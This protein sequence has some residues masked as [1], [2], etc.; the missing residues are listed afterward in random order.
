MAAREGVLKR[1]LNSLF[2]DCLARSGPASFL[3]YLLV[4]CAKKRKYVPFMPRGGQ[5]WARPQRGPGFLCSVSGGQRC[6]TQASQKERRTGSCH[7]KGGKLVQ[8]LFFPEE[9]PSR[10][11]C[12]AV[13]CCRE[14]CGDGGGLGRAGEKNIGEDVQPG[15]SGPPCVLG[16]VPLITLGL[17]IFTVLRYFI[18][19]V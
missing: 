6:R 3:K 13:F 12:L 2:E 16:P 4:I 1:F 11:L 5:S 19:N 10:S 7:K 17:S 15:D 18:H 9:W 14:P 8:I